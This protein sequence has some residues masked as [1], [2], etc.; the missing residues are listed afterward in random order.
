MPAQQGVCGGPPR[1]LLAPRRG[2]GS[3]GPPALEGRRA[4]LRVVTRQQLRVVTRQ[5]AAQAA[6]ACARGAAQPCLLLL[7]LL[8][9]CRPRNRD[10]KPAAAPAAGHELLLLTRAPAA[11]DVCKRCAPAA[12]CRL[13]LGTRPA[14]T[15]CCWLPCMELLA[16][17]VW[18]GLCPRTS[19]P[20]G[21]AHPVPNCQLRQL[22]P[23][24]CQLR[25]GAFGCHG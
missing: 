23:G 14:P 3:G 7:L 2:A 5:P 25:C 20:V 10:G 22:L 1:K 19:W 8:R 6:A 11:L 18:G 12:R 4:Q 9:G 15:A 17:R 24:G 13:Q 21:L 16:A